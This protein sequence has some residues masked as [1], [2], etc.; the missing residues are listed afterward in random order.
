MKY[1]ETLNRP[2]LIVEFVQKLF[3]TTEV[4]KK[5]KF[6]EKYES[7]REREGRANIAVNFD[8]QKLR[9]TFT[10]E[11]N[12]KGKGEDKERSEIAR[13]FRATIAPENNEKAEEKLERLITKEMFGK[14]E[15][16]GQFNQGFNIT[17]HGDD[18]FIIDQHACKI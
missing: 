2:L 1:C 17:K 13:T 18:L 6:D 4:K 10:V 5:V 3:M 16:I 11:K 9:E 15:I 12:S 8:L 14:M 7:E